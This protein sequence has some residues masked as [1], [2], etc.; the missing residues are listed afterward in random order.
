MVERVRRS[1]TRHPLSHDLLLEAPSTSAD[2]GSGWKARPCVGSVSTSFRL[3][4]VYTDTGE[5]YG[6]F[7]SLPLAQKQ[8]RA[9]LVAKHVHEGGR[10]ASVGLSGQGT[11]LLLLGQ[12]NCRRSW[13][14]FK[15]RW[16]VSSRSLSGL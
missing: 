5:V 16:L 11:A 12:V 10:A 3:G 14:T 13:Q 8:A 7:G 6:P 9:K 15:R 4:K 2:H 1:S